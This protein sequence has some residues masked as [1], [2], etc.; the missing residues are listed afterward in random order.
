MGLGEK[1]CVKEAKA[2]ENFTED[3]AVS[4]VRYFDQR[5]ARQGLKVNTGIRDMEATG[6][7][8]FWG[9]QEHKTWDS[10]ER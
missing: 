8:S 4:C 9:A 7:G 10:D 3:G 6:E 1:H 2:K 5:Q